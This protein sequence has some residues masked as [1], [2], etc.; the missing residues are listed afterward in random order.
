MW[1]GKDMRMRIIRISFEVCGHI[2]WGRKGGE[3]ER[4]GRPI[5]P[6]LSPEPQVNV[7]QQSEDQSKQIE[8]GDD[9]HRMDEDKCFI[10]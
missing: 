7:D 2:M 6:N 3:A 1:M 4:A 8:N 5:G 10:I 9:G